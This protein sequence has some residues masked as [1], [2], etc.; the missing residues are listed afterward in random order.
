MVQ[1]TRIVFVLETRFL[2]YH[3]QTGSQLLLTGDYGQNPFNEGVWGQSLV[4]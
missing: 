3:G 1:A 2:S 4:S